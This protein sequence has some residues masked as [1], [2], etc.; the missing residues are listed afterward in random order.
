METTNIRIQAGQAFYEA[1]LREQ[2]KR[3]SKSGKKT[4]L[5][6]IIIEI[7]NNY[8]LSDPFD[9]KSDQKTPGNDQNSAQKGSKEPEFASEKHLKMIKSLEEFLLSRETVLIRREHDLSEREERLR[10]ETDKFFDDKTEFL[11]RQLCRQ[12]QSI[13]GVVES[14]IAQD[15]AKKEISAKNDQLVAPKGRDQLSA[16]AGRKKTVANRKKGRAIPNG[17]ADALSAQHYHHRGHVHDVPQ[18]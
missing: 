12:N 9:Q 2:E 10:T 7:C 14:R 15:L 6:D 18:I 3:R 4:S 17:K 13:D 16:Q 11:D 8:L 5:S 1:L